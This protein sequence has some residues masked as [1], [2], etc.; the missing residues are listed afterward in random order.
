MNDNDDR[1]YKC[2]EEIR[3]NTEPDGVIYVRREKE[4]R[5]ANVPICTYCWFSQNPHR[6]PVR[7]R[8][9]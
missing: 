3:P 1:C 2:G 4:G 9:A 6:V 8:W 5:Y 7:L